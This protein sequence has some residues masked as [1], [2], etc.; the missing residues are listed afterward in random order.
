MS[1][2][3]KLNNKIETKSL[4]ARARKKAPNEFFQSFYQIHKCREVA[5]GCVA[6]NAGSCTFLQLLYHT[7]TW[8][9]AGDQVCFYALNTIARANRKMFIFPHKEMTILS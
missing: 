2:R 8:F 3:L 7:I 4:I 6:K 5:T 1:A 9:C